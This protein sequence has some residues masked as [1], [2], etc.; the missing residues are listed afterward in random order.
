VVADI[1]DL[2]FPD[3]SAEAVYAGHVLEHIEYHEVGAA[4]TEIRRV[5]QPGGRLGVVGPDM[6]RAVGEFAEFAP[7]IWPGLTGEWSS[8]PGA[9]HQ[10][11]PTAEN[12]LAL[13]LPVFPNARE[14]PVSELDGFW[15]ILDR[16]G[17]QFA[18]EATK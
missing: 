1:R 17:W 12:T 5:L 4:L 10:Y 7:C 16:G 8:W 9:R 6:D 13:I 3:G 14:V 11:I 18:F 15:P 2:P